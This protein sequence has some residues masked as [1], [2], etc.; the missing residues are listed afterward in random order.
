MSS[1]S[2][3]NNT[4]IEFGTN[5][6]S[7]DTQTLKL[8]FNAASGPNPATIDFE[9]VDG[10][11]DVA[12]TGIKSIIVSDTTPSTAASLASKSYVDSVASGLKVKGSVRVAS[13]GNLDLSAGGIDAGEEVDGIT[14]VEN[15]RILLK[16]QSNESQNGIYVV[17]AS[18]GDVAR[19]TDMAAG[20]AA[21]GIF[22]FVTE[23]TTQADI[24]YVCISDSGSDT[25]GT[26]DLAFSQF[27]GAGALTAGD[28]IAISGNTVSTDLAAGTGI[29]IAG[30][31]T[32]TFSINLTASN[33]I[34][35]DGDT[36]SHDMSGGTGISVSSAGE[37]SSDL[38]VSSEMNLSGAHELSLAS[39]LSG[40]TYT[41]SASGFKMGADVAGVISKVDGSTPQVLIGIDRTSLSEGLA[42]ASAG[43]D[44]KIAGDLE[45]VDIVTTGSLDINSNMTVSSAGAVSAVSLDL[46]NGG[47]NTL[48]SGTLDV[49]DG[50]VTIS[51]AGAI[52][53][54]SSITGLTVRAT[55]DVTFKENIHSIH[56][57]L[58]IIKALRPVTWTWKDKSLGCGDQPESGIIAQEVEQ[59]E[60]AS[61]A[62]STCE[63]GHKVV[64][65][66][67]LTGLLISAVKNLSDRLDEVSANAGTTTKWLRPR[68]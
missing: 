24:G 56:N 64:N 29:S 25:I 27:T 21:A 62:V 66:N 58:D 17:P 15:D 16:D 37:I 33:G 41:E 1:F 6:G 55:S 34:A 48:K 39:A 8:N 43:T 53:S 52:A 57:G 65:Y 10:D 63:D 11:A 3:L 42:S 18:G 35:L 47:T 7:S 61:H 67:S 5:D 44:I 50:N 45:C 40:H 22:T 46:G 26:H 31:S 30:T 13:T 14:L 20:G 23:G 59:V 49:G 68:K 2:Q 12:M 28:G 51:N 19:A 54:V 4:S 32:R 36:L 38:S 9:G 60:G